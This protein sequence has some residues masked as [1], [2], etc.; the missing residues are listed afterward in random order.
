[1]IDDEIISVGEARKLMPETTEKMNDEQI[2][3]LL[4]NLGLL[5]TAFI[6]AVRKDNEYRVNIA[7]NRGERA[8]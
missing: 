1:M 3:A 2:Q 4:N 6:E 7:Y 8:E 5:A